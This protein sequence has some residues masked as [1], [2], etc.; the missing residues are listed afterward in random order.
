MPHQTSY[1]T[2]H[3]PAYAGQIATQLPYSVASGNVEASAGIAF[4]VPVVIGTG[5]R[6]VKV[7]AAAGDDKFV[8]I[9][10][11]SEGVDHV[12]TTDTD[13][14]LQY[15]E[16]AY[17][18]KGEIWV[19]VGAN[20]VDGGDVFF[21]ETDG[22]WLAAADDDVTQVPNAKYMT[23]ATSGNLAKIRLG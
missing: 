4:G 2:T 17:L 10:V 20:V 18:I 6:N 23:T 21:D 5:D 15:S 11:R 19:T 8:G 14:Y 22:T 13:K 1:S 12:T 9:S 3:S 7:P 16:C